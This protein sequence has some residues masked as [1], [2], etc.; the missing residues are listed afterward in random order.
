[1]LRIWL[2]EEWTPLPCHRLIGE[3]CAAV[4]IAR[5]EAGGCFIPHTT[6]PLAH[7][8]TTAWL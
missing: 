7:P 3:R 8:A 4:Y 1:V 2:D 5:R 6:S